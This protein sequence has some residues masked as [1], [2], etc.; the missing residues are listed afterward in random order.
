MLGIAPA[1]LFLLPLH[2]VL[3]ELIIDPTCSIVLERQPA[4]EDIMDRPP[5]DPKEPMLTRG[6]L[7][8]SI[9]QGLVIFAAAF[10]TYFWTL[11]G[12]P[13]NAPVARAMGLGIVMLANLLLVQVNCSDHDFVVHSIRRLARDKIMWLVNIVT[14]AG[15]AAILYTPLADVLKLAPLSW[16]Q[17]LV[18]LGMALAATL[19]YELVKAAR[20][21]A[22]RAQRRTHFPEGGL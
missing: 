5:R 12:K 9:V 15:L 18:V 6:G 17:V 8:K 20:K 11:A 16:G 10:G 7:I 3:L 22:K 4:E 2:V 19:W 21:A 14:L 13:A 1:S